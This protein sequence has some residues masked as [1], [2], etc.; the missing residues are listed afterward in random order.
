MKGNRKWLALL[1]AV[2]MTAALLVPAF[3]Q[4]TQVDHTKVQITKTLK[5]G[6]GITV[7]DVTFTFT[8]TKAT[9]AD[10]QLLGEEGVFLD[11]NE[12]QSGVNYPDLASVSIVY[13][14][15]MRG[16]GATDTELTYLTPEIDLTQTNWPQSGLYI[17]S[18]KE[19]AGT[20]SGMSY[21]STTVYYLKVYVTKDANGNNQV[22]YVGVM[23]KND[24][25]QWVKVDAAPTDKKEANNTAVIDGVDDF[26]GNDFRFTNSY[27][28]LVDKHPYNANPTS[29]D[30]DSNGFSDYAFKLTKDVV[31]DFSSS[32]DSFEY[33]LSVILPDTY[34]TFTPV[35]A[36]VNHL[37]AYRIDPTSVTEPTTPAQMA[38]VVSVTL[39]ATVLSGADFSITLRHG[40]SFSIDQLPAGTVIN[41]KEHDFTLRAYAP[42]YS[43]KWGLDTTNNNLKTDSKGAHNDL[44]SGDIVVGENG[45]YIQYTNT[46]DNVTPTGIVISNL[47]Y[48]LM[49]VIALGGIGF[50]LVSK[51]RRA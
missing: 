37:S 13:D 35:T 18:V 25:D 17:Y 12:T 3:A 29:G 20:E 1:L 46:M 8:F 38:E 49:V 2:I 27:V 28:K 45:A 51:K 30:T 11:P 4:S 10:A 5:I 26:R 31:G 48:I 24:Q 44:E 36:R 7:P 32:S 6:Q 33:T 43:G 50:Y 22:E 16:D 14:A 9:K 23:G 34:K 42:S 15:T 47:P 19:E 21:D 41:V 39:P 40:D